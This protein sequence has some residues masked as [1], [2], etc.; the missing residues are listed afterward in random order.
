[1]INTKLDC[2]NLNGEGHEM[3]GLWD[4]IVSTINTDATKAAVQK[5]IDTNKQKAIS[6]AITLASNTAGKI[7]DK[8]GA[9]KP[10]ALS[11][12]NKVVGAA[13][14]GAQAS[15]WENNKKKIY[16]TGGVAIGL[17][18]IAAYLKFKK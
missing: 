3:G 16:I 17:I 1:M 4:S 2:G 6:S 12:I 14:E 15:F 13:T 10:S 18:G 9:T 8:T 11:A 5:A 7:L